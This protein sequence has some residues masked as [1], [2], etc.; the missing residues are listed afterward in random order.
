MIQCTL[1]VRY[2]EDVRWHLFSFFFS[3][4]FFGFILFYTFVG[5]KK[6]EIGKGDGTIGTVGGKS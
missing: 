4:F 6:W 2:R 5:G 3:H 1:L